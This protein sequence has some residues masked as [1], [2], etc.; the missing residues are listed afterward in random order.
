MKT[1]KQKMAN[2]F[3]KRIRNKARHLKRKS[4]KGLLTVQQSIIMGLD[5]VHEVK[6]LHRLMS[7]KPK[8]NF[9]KGGFV[10]GNLNEPEYILGKLNEIINNLKQKL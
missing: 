2:G 10:A 4:R 1:E 5:L 9:P 7:N 8:P 3:K 6:G